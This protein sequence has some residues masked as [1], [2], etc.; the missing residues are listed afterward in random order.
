MI[1]TLYIKWNEKHSLINLSMTQIRELVKKFGKKNK[2]GYI[3]GTPNRESCIK[4]GKIYLSFEVSNL[5]P[6]QATGEL[7][8][9][10][11]KE[12]SLH[13]GKKMVFDRWNIQLNEIFEQCSRFTDPMIYRKILKTDKY[14]STAIEHWIEKTPVFIVDKA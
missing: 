7:G 13:S 11:A 8:D 1:E 14:N 4:N 3:F 10:L 9:K 6:K 2:L 5:R 12:L